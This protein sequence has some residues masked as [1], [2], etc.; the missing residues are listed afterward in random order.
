M[1]CPRTQHNV[2]SQDFNLD[3]SIQR[4]HHTSYRT[5]G[6]IPKI[7]KFENRPLSR[8]SHFE[9]QENKKLCFCLSSLALHERLD[10]QNLLFNHCVIKFY[11]IQIENCY[12]RKNTMSQSYQRV[13]LT[14]SQDC[15]TRR[16]K[17]NLPHSRSI[18]PVPGL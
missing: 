2:P 14:F 3:H 4:G 7:L 17:I 8:G 9:S 16:A 11:W 18:C 1:S 10:G 5:N 13:S 12:T 15:Q 6:A